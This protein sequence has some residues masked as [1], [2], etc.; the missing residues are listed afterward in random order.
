MAKNYYI[1]TEQEKNINHVHDLLKRTHNYYFV[2][3]IC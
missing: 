1:P 3:S 2:P